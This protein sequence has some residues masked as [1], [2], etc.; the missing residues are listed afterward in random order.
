VSEGGPQDFVVAGEVSEKTCL[1][2]KEEL[3]LFPF[4]EKEELLEMPCYFQPQEYAAGEIVCE[5]G[6]PCDFVGFI[7]SGSCEIK[8]ETEFKGK[9]FVLGIYSAGSTVGELCICD[10]SPR[11]YTAVALEKTTLIKISRDNFSKMLEERPDLGA[12]FLKGLLLATSIRL[13]K[14]FDRMASIF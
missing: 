14:S 13:R 2:M 12:K 3:S 5:E 9:T 6:G 10:N 7:V 8:K 4:L 11:P 1:V